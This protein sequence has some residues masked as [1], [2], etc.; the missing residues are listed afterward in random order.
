MGIGR[1]ILFD[2]TV[3]CQ[4]PCQIDFGAQDEAKGLADKHVKVLAK[5]LADFA[6]DDKKVSDAFLIVATERHTQVR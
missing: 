5:Q 3:P 4:T 2:L 6:R 1:P